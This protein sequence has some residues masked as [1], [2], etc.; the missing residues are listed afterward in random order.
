MCESL[1]RSRRGQ[2]STVSCGATHMVMLCDPLPWC[3]YSVD[4][5]AGR[6]RMVYPLQYQLPRLG[7]LRRFFELVELENV[8]DWGY[9]NQT[10]FHEDLMV[11]DMICSIW[12]KDTD[13]MVNIGQPVDVITSEPRKYAAAGTTVSQPENPW[14]TPTRHGQVAQQISH[15]FT[16]ADLLV[17][18]SWRLSEQPSFD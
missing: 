15:V 18:R 5:C 7:P 12:R 17:N 10:K 14:F 11:K 1:I 4:R 6:R 3:I 2:S 9:G 8:R 16:L 13:N